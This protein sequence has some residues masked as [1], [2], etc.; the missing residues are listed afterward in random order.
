MLSSLN[1]LRKRISPKDDSYQYFDNKDF[2]LNTLQSRL[3][4]RG[5]PDQWTRMR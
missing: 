2:G 4:V 3:N 5:G 1:S